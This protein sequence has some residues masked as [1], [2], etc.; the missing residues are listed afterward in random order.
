[1]ISEAALEALK[2]FVPSENIRLRERMSEH[3]TFRIG[4]EADC[5]IELE[6]K[7]QLL[8][9][10][11]Y[12]TAIEEPFFILG[13]G[14][15][16]LVSDEGYRGVIL[17]IGRKMSQIRVEGSRMIAGAGAL[18]SQVAKAAL[19]HGLTG[20]EF[21][22]GIP[23]TVGG[24]VVMNAG[25]YGGE[26]SQVVAE[27]TVTSRDGEVLILDNESMEFGYRISTIKNHP[28]VVTEVAFELEG[29]DRQLIQEKMEDL[30][31][32]RREKQPLE[33]PS[34]G[35]TFKR[36]EGYF[37]GELIM[38]AGLRGFQIGGARVSDKHCGFVVNTG[39]ATAADVK[40]VVD[41]IRERVKDIFHVE[42]Q[43]EIV[44]LGRF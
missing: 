3:T 31:A 40:D 29:G 24:G 34:A 16:I 36:P 6:N 42:L 14:S 37:A 19:A 33:Y 12:L 15:N 20:L 38:K 27:V 9:V 23:G 26:M 22:C 32:R 43:P 2:G 44:F 35:S 17:Q 21:A 7:E 13:N 1:M 5:F 11:K 28:F 18:L 4:G 39:R 25:A 41:E 8:K 10:Q 30:A